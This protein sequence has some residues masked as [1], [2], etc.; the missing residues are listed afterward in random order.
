[1][2][3]AISVR[4]S[5]IFPPLGSAPGLRLSQR[6]RQIPW[7]LVILITMVASIGFVGKLFAPAGDVNGDGYDDL[8]VAVG[9]ALADLDLGPLISG[10]QKDIVSGF[11]AAGKDLNLA[12]R[13]TIIENAIGGSGADT[14][15]VG[16]LLARS[17]L[18]SS[19][20]SRESAMPLVVSRSDLRSCARRL[21]TSCLLR[22]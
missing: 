2:I 9:P 20:P 13:G 18:C 3:T 7:S 21:A 11:V 4:R 16:R 1:M 15:V 6:I 14:L 17:Y 19:R 12:A 22:G 8:I 10:K 5:W